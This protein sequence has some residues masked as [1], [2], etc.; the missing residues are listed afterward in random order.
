MV[1]RGGG[2]YSPPTARDV[3]LRLLDCAVNDDT[4][5]SVLS[6]LEAGIKAVAARIDALPDAAQFKVEVEVIENFLGTAYVLC[7][8]QI[9][10]VTEAA[11]WVRKVAPDNSTLPDKAHEIRNLGDKFNNS[12]YSKIDVLW[13]LA[14]YFKH[15]DEWCPSTW[16]NPTGKAKY[17]VPVLKAAGLQTC[18][19]GNLRT[20]AEVLGN[21]DYANLAVFED[22]IA[23]W[24][25][26]VGRC[27]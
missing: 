16:T 18:S 4:Y 24:A 12:S 5:A 21:D 3:A 11:L 10:A 20:G 14:N 6:A 27:V 9:T 19:T 22:I 23:H 7:Q 8:T 15:R 2:Q 17:T 13:A 1:G 25:E 26:E